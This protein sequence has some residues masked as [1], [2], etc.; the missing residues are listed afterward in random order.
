M[1]H[2]E[3][4]NRWADVPKFAMKRFSFGMRWWQDVYFNEHE[5]IY[6]LEFRR[7]YPSL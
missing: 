7:A 5:H 6:P 3:R 1:K 2:L 4:Q